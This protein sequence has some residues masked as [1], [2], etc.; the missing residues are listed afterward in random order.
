M[1]KRVILPEKHSWSKSRKDKKTLFSSLFWTLPTLPSRLGQMSAISQN[2]LLI[3]GR[4]SFHLAEYFL[5]SERNCDF[6]W[7]TQVVEHI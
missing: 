4:S 5:Y 3:S 7:H 2:K 1:K 6:A